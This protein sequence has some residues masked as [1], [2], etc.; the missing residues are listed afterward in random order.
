MKICIMK[1][2]D[3]IKSYLS[4]TNVDQMGLVINKIHR[5][6]RMDVTATE[7]DKIVKS[8]SSYES[9]S[10]NYGINEEVV[11]TIKAMFR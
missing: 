9:I 8:V 11:Y 6:H 10:R 5:E 1:D 7:V 3:I 4:L 2:K